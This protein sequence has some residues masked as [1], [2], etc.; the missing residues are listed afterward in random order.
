MLTSNR[1]LRKETPMKLFSTIAISLICCAIGHSASGQS[2]FRGIPAEHHVF[3]PADGV[4]TRDVTFYSD[5]TACWARVFFPKG[6]DVKG[7]TPAIVVAHGWTGFHD[8]L[9]KYGNCFADAGFVAMVIDYRG[10]GNSDGF[11]SMVD[12]VKTTDDKRFT[13]AT[14]KVQIKRTRLVPLKQVDDIRAAI[15]FIQGEP[16]VDPARIGL[17]GSSFAGGHVLTVASQDPRVRAVVSQVS[18]IAG[19]GMPEGPLPMTDAETKDAI[20]AAR[21]GQGGQF[22]TGFTTPRFVDQET[23]RLSKE[24]RPFHS[25]KNIPETVAVLFLLA[26][27]E[28]LIDNSK[29]GKAAYEL[30]RGP[31]KLVEYPGIGHFDIYIEDNFPKASGEAVNWYKEHLAAK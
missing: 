21:T 17:W 22:E 2:K 7:K 15:S 6:Y 9:L 5:G 3:A 1:L 12:R 4:T 24:Y 16:G 31:K 29:A 26:G 28:E 30:L 14:T 23:G 11:V 10:W 20:Q 19:N 13:E 8:S 27:N 25:V 18:A